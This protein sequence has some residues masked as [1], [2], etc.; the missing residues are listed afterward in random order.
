MNLLVWKFDVR[1]IKKGFGWL[2]SNVIFEKDVKK[3]T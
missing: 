3:D 2:D 1:V